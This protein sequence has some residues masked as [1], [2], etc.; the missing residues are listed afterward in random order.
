MGSP[1]VD[2]TTAKWSSAFVAAAP[3]A[4]L[5]SRSPQTLRMLLRMIVRLLARTNVPPMRSPKKL[6]PG[7]LA[8]LAVR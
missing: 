4:L 5:S 2:I 7:P 1:T 6:D 3:T 8:G